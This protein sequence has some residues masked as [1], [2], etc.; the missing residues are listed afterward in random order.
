LVRSG[1]AADVVI[2]GG[3]IAGTALAYHLAALDAGRVLVVEQ[4]EL[5]AGTTWH[6]A[7]AVGRMRVSPALARLNQRSAAMYARMERETGLPT[8]WIEAGS[9]T[10]ARTDERMTQLRRA[11]G[12]ASSFGVEVAE[13]DRSA[14]ARHWPFAQF[15]DVE[16][17]IWLPGDG[18]VDPVLLVRAIA[19]GARRRGAEI[20]E[21]VRV[22]GLGLGSRGH[23]SRPRG[24]RG[25]PRITAVETDAGP[26]E[27]RRVVLCTGMWTPQIARAA[28]LAVPVQPVEHHYVMSNPVDGAVDHMPVVRDPDGCIY[29]RARDG[30]LMLGAFQATS[31][32]WD[33]S[34]VPDDFAFQLLEP[35]WE[36]FAPPLQEGLARLPG[37]RELGI[38]RFVNGP[39]SF[40]PDGNPIIG[41]LPGVD[42]LF[43]C[44]AFNSSGLA[45]GGG[46]GEALAEWLV[47]GEP[48]FDLWALDVRRFS[49]DQ[50]RPEFL[51]TRG[52]EVLGAHMRIAYPNVEWEQGRGMRRSPLHDRLVQA[53]ACH[54][55]KFGVERPNWFA[56]DGRPARM[57]YSF[58]RPDWFDDVRTEHLATRAR[59]GVFDLSSFGKLEV[60]G[61]DALPLLQYACANDVD[62]PPGKVVYTA[63]LTDRGTFASDLTVLRLAPERFL[64]VTGTAQRVADREWLHARSPEGAHVRIADVSE[65]W[66]VLGLMGPRSRDIL[67]ELCHGDLS[68]AAFPF[69]TAQK[70][71]I[72]GIPCRALRITYVGELGWELQVPRGRAVELYEALRASAGADALADAGYY[73]INSLRLEKGYRQWGADITLNDTPLEAGLSFAVAWDKEVPFHG[74]DALLAQRD[75]G[76]WRRLVSVLLH[77]PEPMLWG[78]ERLFVDDECVGYTTSGAYGHSLGAAVGLGYLEAGTEPITEDAL[79]RTPFEVDIAGARVPARAALRPLFDPDRARIFT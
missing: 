14:L 5:A 31:K 23:G 10:I 13:L 48:P 15:D 6:A 75:N 18:V 3:G 78:G 38:E 45:Y 11:G 30:S 58:E 33:V 9:Y 27:A 65:E 53:N 60:E 49:P 76:P 34:R 50:A 43:V 22:T 37:L 70:L 69:S 52:V 77:D 36:H 56:H 46:V 21:G 32:P 20:R 17:G 2:V 8:G 64:V 63:M 72:A 42:G 67:G 41:E 39:E 44:T 29:F 24:D 28:G 54:G 35:D 51:R 4:N 71:D 68:D 55:E 40:A 79:E 16:G 47:G 12:M 25:R 66:A 26:I 74:R 57:S 19:E 61:A 73:A 62:V 1:T 59:A 7:G